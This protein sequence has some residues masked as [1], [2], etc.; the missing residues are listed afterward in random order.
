VSRWGKT[1]YGRDAERKTREAYNESTESINNAY[2]VLLEVERELKSD[3]EFNKWVKNAPRKGGL[4]KEIA[5]DG[6]QDGD[7]FKA[8]IER[9]IANKSDKEIREYRTLVE[10]YAETK[11]TEAKR[12][13]KTRKK[14]Q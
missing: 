2:K 6:I 8:D 10:E 3:G 1:T 13:A 5:Q 7:A 14:L 4:T 11:E 9:N 12:I